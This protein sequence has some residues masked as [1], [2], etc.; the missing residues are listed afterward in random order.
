M[1]RRRHLPFAID[2]SQRDQ[3]M[4]CMNQTLDEQIEEP[5]RQQLKD[6]FYKVADHMKNQ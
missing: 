6:A 4:L 3:W 2:E 1:L 5:I